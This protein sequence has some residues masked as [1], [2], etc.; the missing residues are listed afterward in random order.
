MVVVVFVIMFFLLPDYCRIF[1]G[2]GGAEVFMNSLIETVAEPIVDLELP[3]PRFKDL[4]YLSPIVGDS[5]KII[6]FLPTKLAI[7][8]LARTGLKDGPSLEC[9]GTSA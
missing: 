7:L 1:G 2:G 9:F 5:G 3:S 8:F 4:F 6:G